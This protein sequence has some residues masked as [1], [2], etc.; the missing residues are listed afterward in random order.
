MTFLLVT[1][2]CATLDSVLHTVCGLALHYCKFV[3]SLFFPNK[4]LSYWENKVLISG[5]FHH[6]SM[7]QLK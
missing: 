7:L 3:T 6:S 1:F 4:Y 5:F 2:L